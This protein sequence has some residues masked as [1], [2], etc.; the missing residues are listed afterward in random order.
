[1]TPINRPSVSWVATTI[2][3]VSLSFSTSAAAAESLDSHAI[4]ALAVEG[5]WVSEDTAYGNWTWESDLSVCVVLPTLGDDCADTGTWQVDDDVMCYELTWWGE[6]Y[7]IR[8]NCFTVHALNDDRY[9]ARYHNTGMDSVF[10]TFEV[11]P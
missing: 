1:M 6:S 3:M 2:A 11:V 8:T 7:N 4:R 10:I 5:T 9:E